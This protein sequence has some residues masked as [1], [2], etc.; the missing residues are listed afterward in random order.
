MRYGTRPAWLTDQFK[1]WLTLPDVNPFET[2]TG[3]HKLLTNLRE[4]LCLK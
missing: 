1:S 3:D 2:S 4:P